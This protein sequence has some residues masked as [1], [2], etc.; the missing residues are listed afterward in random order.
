MNQYLFRFFVLILTI[1]SVMVL[2]W[3]ISVIILIGLTVYLKLYIEIIFFG[4]LFDVMYPAR[5]VFPLTFLSCA[6]IFLLVVMFVKT[7]IRT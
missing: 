6:T 7:H 2:P 5:Y 3:W 1:I 4:F